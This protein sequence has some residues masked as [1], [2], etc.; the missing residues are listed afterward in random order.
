MTQAPLPSWIQNVY[1]AN[2][3]NKRTLV[4]HHTI[5]KIMRTLQEKQTMMWK[6]NNLNIST[7]PHWTQQ[8][9]YYN[10][11][12][13]GSPHISMYQIAFLDQFTENITSNTEYRDNLS[14]GYACAE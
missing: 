9:I 1:E 5:P 4:R 6:L 12:D 3:R 10:R 14:E 13:A 8:M 7:S 11:M 2:F